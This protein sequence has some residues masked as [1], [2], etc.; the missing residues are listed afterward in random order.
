VAG[1]DA[2]STR[3]DRDGDWRRILAEGIA[4][5]VQQAWLIRRVAAQASQGPARL[6]RP[7]LL[8]EH[9]F[10]RFEK[11]LG[12]TILVAHLTA[13][14]AAV[15]E[16]LRRQARDL[17][18][19]L[20]SLVAHG[21]Y[22]RVWL[23]LPYSSVTSVGAAQ[24]LLRDLGV[25]DKEATEDLMRAAAKTEAQWT[26]RASRHLLERSWFWAHMKP[27]LR[28]YPKPD[29]PQRL[30]HPI[31]LLR[32]DIYALTHDVWFGT[33]LGR[34]RLQHLSNV[35]DVLQAC[36]PW[37]ALIGDLDCLGEVIACLFMLGI[38]PCD[39]LETAYQRLIYGQIQ[40]M[41]TRPDGSGGRRLLFF[42]RS[43]PT[44]T[45]VID[46]HPIYVAAIAALVQ[47]Q[48]QLQST[49]TPAGTTAHADLVRMAEQQ[50]RIYPSLPSLQR[51]TLLGLLSPAAVLDGLLIAAARQYRLD[52][53]DELLAAAASLGLPSSWTAQAA[54]SFVHSQT[55]R[56]ASLPAS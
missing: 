54:E 55:G 2:P 16:E 8:V 22:R 29:W 7:F 24:A 28:S 27:G 13:T 47:E 20:A 32:S 53:I 30:P 11:W 1:G 52:W 48:R 6:D 56:P 46:Y 49:P 37:L 42:H 4:V 41:A 33:D 44:P 35:A 34:H 36:A 5:A 40:K 51:R 43:A 10:G 31:Y 38:R 23:R 17:A 9:P 39:G 19:S 45:R 26:E 12:E 15:P 50:L 21:A 3:L 25:D 18:A 14:T